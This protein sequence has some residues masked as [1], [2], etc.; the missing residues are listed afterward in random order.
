MVTALS[1]ANRFAE[2]PPLGPDVIAAAAERLVRNSGLKSLTMRRLG[3]ELGVEA[4]SLYHHVANKRD[5]EVTLVARILSRVDADEDDSPVEATGRFARALRRV[6]LDALEVIQNQNR[7]A[8]R[9]FVDQD[10]IRLGQPP[11][12]EEQ[13]DLLRQALG[14]HPIEHLNR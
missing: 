2:H 5:I 8:V 3:R 14:Q 10:Q 1:P 6:L 12:D 4:M 11:I 7:L 13:I 9:E